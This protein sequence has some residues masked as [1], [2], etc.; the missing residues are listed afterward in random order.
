MY[1]RAARDARAEMNDR[2]AL[3][4]VLGRCGV[5]V[6]A[7]D[8]Q[9]GSDGASLVV[10]NVH[11]WSCAMSQRVAAALDAD[12]RAECRSSRRSVSGFVVVL[13]VRPRSAAWAA[14]RRLGA[15]ALAAGAAGALWLCACAWHFSRADANA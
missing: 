3:A 10:S 7:C 13:H 5:A 4:R 14:A 15:A 9:P 6:H 12:V 8:V 2:A 11:H 1:E